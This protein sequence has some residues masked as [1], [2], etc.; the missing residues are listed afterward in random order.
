MVQA[1]LLCNFGIRA[2]SEVSLRFRGRFGST[3][4]NCH[5]DLREAM[6]QKRRSEERCWGKPRDASDWLRNRGAR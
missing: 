6:G 5:T 1:G 2:Y 3:G 4:A